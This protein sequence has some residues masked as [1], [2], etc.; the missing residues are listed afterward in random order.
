MLHAKSVYKKNISLQRVKYSKQLG[1]A[2]RS[3]IKKEK[4]P[5]VIFCAFPLIDLAYEAV[6]Y[7]KENNIPVIVDVRDLWPDIIWEHFPKVIQFPVRLLCSTLISK[8]NFVMK[9]ASAVIGVV[10]KCM[11]FAQKHG[12][13]IG[14]KDA[15]YYLAYKEKEQSTK[16]ILEA[17]A[18]WDKKGV[19]RKDFILCWIGQISSQRTDFELVCNIIANMP[20]CK[21][22]ICGD[23]PSRTQLEEKYKNYSNIIFP[24][25]LNQEELEALMRISSVGIIPIK[26][27]PDFENTINNKAIEYMAGSLCVLTTLKGLLRKTLEQNEMGYYFEND[28]DFQ[29]I[30][31]KLMNNRTLLEKNKHNARMYYESNFKAENV[32]GRLCSVIENLN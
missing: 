31:E 2:F 27:T 1:D 10:P 22:V 18:Y 12:R 20:E 13:L 24:G 29:K 4:K 28:K 15:V 16:E 32:Y 25:F 3:A 7:G 23:G 30:I 21:L 19:T 6:K 5:D 9:N 11:E 26:N 17:N 8:T 14:N